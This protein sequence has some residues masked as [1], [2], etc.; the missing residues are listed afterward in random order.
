M[1]MIEALSAGLPVIAAR[2]GAIHEVVC[3]GVHGLLYEPSSD[4]GLVAAVRRLLEDETMR[5]S[6]SLRARATAEERDWK[7]ST[8]TLRGYYEEALAFGFEASSR[9]L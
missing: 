8:A 2:T 1:A 4:E 9:R 3:E 5:R 6:F 7:A